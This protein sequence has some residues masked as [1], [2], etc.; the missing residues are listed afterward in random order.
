MITQSTIYEASVL[1]EIAVDKLLKRDESE[2][3]REVFILEWSGEFLY[4]ISSLERIM[5]T[6]LCRF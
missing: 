6:P 5:I 4:R 2:V 3:L 1:I